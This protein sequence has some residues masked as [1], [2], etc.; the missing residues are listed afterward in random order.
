MTENRKGSQNCL[1][2][3]GED[4]DKEAVGVSTMGLER[5]LRTAS[6]TEVRTQTRRPWES[7]LWALKGPQNCLKR[8]TLGGPD[9]K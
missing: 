9:P 4:P 1:R 2:D 7:P 6:E 8:L 3:R 5:D